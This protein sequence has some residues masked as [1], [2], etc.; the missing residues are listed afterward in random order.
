M[1]IIETT[2]LC[3]AWSLQAKKRKIWKDRERKKKIKST[4]AMVRP[5]TTDG[6]QVHLAITA[7]SLSLLSTVLM[8]SLSHHWQNLLE[9]S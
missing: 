1:K 2:C 4:E 9:R 5:G 6:S 8:N 3:Y 7:S